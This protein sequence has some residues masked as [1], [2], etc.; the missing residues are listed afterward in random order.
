M[1]C[2]I[3]M[4]FNKCLKLIYGGVLLIIQTTADNLID[5]V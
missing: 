4:L 3:I 5:I 1:I 2:Y